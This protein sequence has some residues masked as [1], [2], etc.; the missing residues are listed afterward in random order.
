MFRNAFLKLFVAVCICLASA[1]CSYGQGGGIIDV[2]FR[3]NTAETHEL[4]VKNSVKNDVKIFLIASDG[5][6]HFE[7]LLNP[8]EILTNNLPSGTY[9]LMVVEYKTTGR[10]TTYFLRLKD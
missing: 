7:Y 3:Q 9:Q 8:G 6:Q 10:N 4:T 2:V 1:A 5:T